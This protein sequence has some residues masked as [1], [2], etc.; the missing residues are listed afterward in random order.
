VGILISGKDRSDAIR[1]A[2]VLQARFNNHG[3][4]IDVEHCKYHSDLA[5]LNGKV[6]QYEFHVVQIRK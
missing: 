4:R 6:K 1:K 3:Q 5:T 2:T